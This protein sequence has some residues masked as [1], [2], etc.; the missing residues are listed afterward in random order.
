MKLRSREFRNSFLIQATM[1]VMAISPDS[2][3]CFTSCSCESETPEGN[4]AF[5]NSSI[6]C[7]LIIYC[8]VF[9]RH[10]ISI[11][12]KRTFFPD[13]SPYLAWHDRLLQE[14]RAGTAR[15][16]GYCFLL[17]LRRL[18]SLMSFYKKTYCECNVFASTSFFLVGLHR[19]KMAALS[20]E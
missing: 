16:S 6:L 10:S 13:V 5:V 9:F 20:K 18:T 8:L 17:P 19:E 7:I 14:G 4:R 3:E 12:C 1:S 2:P 15:T 11:A